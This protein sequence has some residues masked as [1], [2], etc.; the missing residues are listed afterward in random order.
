MIIIDQRLKYVLILFRIFVVYRC[1]FVR[2]N[3]GSITYERM[4]LKV[5]IR[6]FNYIQTQ[7]FM[8]NRFHLKVKRCLL[9]QTVFK[10]F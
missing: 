3:S 1:L 5:K 4:C 9:I 10:N 2:E 7:E 8:Q 6:I